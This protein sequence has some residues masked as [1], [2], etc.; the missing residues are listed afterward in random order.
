MLGPAAYIL[1]PRCPPNS[2]RLDSEYEKVRI[3]R[4][5]DGYSPGDSNWD[6]NSLPQSGD[7]LSFPDI[8][9]SRSL[10]NNSTSGN[11]YSL[12]FTSS[13]YTVAGNTIALTATGIDLQSSATST[14]LNTPLTFG[15]NTTI[16]IS[17]GTTTLAGALS[18]TDGLT[19]TGAGELLISGSANFTGPTQINAGTLNLTGTLTSD[20][21]LEITNNATFT[22]NPPD[23]RAGVADAF[24]DTDVTYDFSTGLTQGDGRQ[25]SH[26]KDDVLTGTLLGIMDPT[27]SYGTTEGIS[28]ADLRALDLIG[29]DPVPEAGDLAIPAGMGLALA[30][31]RQWRR[32]ARSQESRQAA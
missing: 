10:S 19:K 7:A 1:T 2:R 8:S 23:L 24:S 18:G 17:A 27:L 26:W 32:H 11:A 31:L 14:V 29:W 6:T 15:N 4:Q 28:A 16:N 22:G 30:A 3:L 20:S 21:P 5:T 13:G 12:D 9:T 25:A